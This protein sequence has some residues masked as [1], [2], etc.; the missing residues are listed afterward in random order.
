MNALPDWITTSNTPKNN[1][2]YL[3]C[4]D[5]LLT[6]CIE[7]SNP[8]SDLIC[9]ICGGFFDCL[10]VVTGDRW[11][12][13]VKEC[14]CNEQ[15]QDAKGPKCTCSCGGENHGKSYRYRL[16]TD[17]QG[18]VHVETDID[19]EKHLSTANE[20]REAERAAVNRINALPRKAEYDCGKWIDREAWNKIHNAII[21]LNVARK[22]SQHKSRMTKLAKVAV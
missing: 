8:R 16:H 7:M 2:Y 1:R 21:L 20:Y 13:Q 5:C 22:G 17:A 18:R 6:T 10:G 9:D 12:H 3:R 11:Q 4:H 19:A 15:C 14:V